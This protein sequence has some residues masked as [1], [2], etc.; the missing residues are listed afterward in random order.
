MSQNR[1]WKIIADSSCDLNLPKREENGQEIEM[2]FVPF[3]IS[4]G[5]KDYIDDGSIDIDEMLKAMK[6]EEDIAR[7]ACPSPSTWVEAVTEDDENVIMITISKELSGSYNSACLAKQMLLE[8]NPERNVAVINSYSAGP[9]LATIAE[10]IYDE[11]IAG[12]SFVEVVKVA[13]VVAVKSLTIFAL[14]SFDN[15]VKNGR[16]SK[17]AGFVAGKLNFWG[18]GVATDEGTI[19]VKEKVRGQKKALKSIMTMIENEIGSIYVVHISQ[20]RNQEMVARIK[21]EIEVLDPKVRVVIN[22]TKGLCSFYAEKNGIMI[23]FV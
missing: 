7:T 4:I 10:V 1:K 9:G 13:E 2:V 16:V 22:D 18:I 23:A 11:V 21:E 8:A 15:L 17:L 14:A 20:C 19:A 3:V 12:H 6:E 5:E